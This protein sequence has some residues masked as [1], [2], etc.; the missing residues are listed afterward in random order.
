MAMQQQQA[1]GASGRPVTLGRG[2]RVATSGDRRW[3]VF[4]ASARE[5]VCWPLIGSGCF[6]G[7]SV[8][9]ARHVASSCGDDDAP[10]HQSTDSTRSRER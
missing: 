7:G 5:G 4:A 1:A 10:E 9:A 2:C 6:G 8:R 3:L